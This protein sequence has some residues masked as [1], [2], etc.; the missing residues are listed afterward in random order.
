MQ[1]FSKLVVWGKAHSLVLEV[2]LATK[3]FPQT[4]RYGLTMQ[5]RRA[6]SSVA[7]NIA[8][9]R[10]RIGEGEF[11]RF[12]RIALG[13]AT[14]LEYHLLLARDLSLVDP[15][16]HD[17]LAGELRLVQRMLASLIRKLRSPQAAS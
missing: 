15:S 9:G 12:L 16:Q 17:K 4:E 2:Y 13:S 11:G 7:A 6:A 3:A 10:G 5:L 1:H 14:E 8:E